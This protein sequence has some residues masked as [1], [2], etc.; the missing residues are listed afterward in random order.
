MRAQHVLADIKKQFASILMENPQERQNSV[1]FVHS[2][3][4]EQHCAAAV[5]MFEHHNTQINAYNL[6]DL[7]ATWD[8]CKT[9]ARLPDIKIADYLK[10]PQGSFNPK[11]LIEY[12]RL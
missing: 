6:H 7:I 9:M 10:I 11:H 5:W 12:F 8:E 4:E 3:L 2:H 1:G